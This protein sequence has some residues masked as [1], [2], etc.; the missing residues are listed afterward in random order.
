MRFR[1]IAASIALL[2]LAG[3]METAEV[4][5]TGAQDSSSSAPSQAETWVET[6][7]EADT[8]QIEMDAQQPDSTGDTTDADSDG[9][10]NDGSIS[11]DWAEN[12]SVEEYEEYD[13]DESDYRVEVMLTANKDVKDLRLISLNYEN[14]R[15]DGSPI[16]LYD[17]LH[18]FGDLEKGRSL[19]VR[20]SFPGDMPNYGISYKDEKDVIRYCALQQSGKDGSLILWEF[21]SADEVKLRIGDIPVN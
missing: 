13:A 1:F 16:F 9:Y 2:L 20:M 4:S 12:V 10:R 5:Q 11:A 14:V 15:E 6:P 8:Q 3:C 17:D 19:L 7:E 18:E 21:Q